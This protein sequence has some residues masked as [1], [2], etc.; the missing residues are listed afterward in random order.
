[1][2]T[3]AY[4]VIAFHGPATICTQP[5]PMS[6]LRHASFDGKYEPGNLETNRLRLH[7]VSS[8][9]TPYLGSVQILA[10]SLPP[11]SLSVCCPK[12]ESFRRPWV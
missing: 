1:M 3:K 5:F 7:R 9:N 8:R 2:F 10:Q 11:G 12:V 6:D 4:P